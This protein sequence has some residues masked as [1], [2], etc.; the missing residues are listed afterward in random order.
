[1]DVLQCWKLQADFIRHLLEQLSLYMDGIF[2][3]Q[4]KIMIVKTLRGVVVITTNVA[5]D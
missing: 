2:M 4:S 1:M 3:L 5:R